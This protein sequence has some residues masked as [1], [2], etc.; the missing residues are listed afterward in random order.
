MLKTQNCAKLRSKGPHEMD[1][2][3]T[4]HKG[5]TPGCI[6]AFTVV[7]L[8]AHGI[9]S[10]G[11]LVAVM[12][13][14]SG[15]EAYVM[16][17]MFP[18]KSL[19]LFLI[20]FIVGIAAGPITDTLFKPGSVLAEKMSGHLEFHKEDECICY[21]KGEILNQYRN[22]SLERASLILLLVLFTAAL[23]INQLGPPAWNWIK[24][25]LLISSLLALFV[26]STVPEHF[27]EEHLWEHIV[28]VHIPR[29]FLWTFGALLAMYFLMDYLALGGWIKANYLTVMV[30]ACLI[31]LI[32][33][34]GPH[35]IFVTLYAQ[36]A[37]PFGVLLA[38]SIVQDGH[39]MLPL[40]AESKRSFLSVKMI[41]FV[42]ALV[43]GIVCYVAGF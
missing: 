28:K 7:A 43:A 30:I 12:I 2:G 16:L 21:P 36:G 29:V 38:S 6:G 15:D 13:A 23:L 31:G 35:M 1:K 4:L 26:V 10:F 39:G 19:L 20:T 8:Y 14:T 33:E 22:L 25:T 3:F 34:S 41:N 40:L 42:V 11:A 24:V 17:S 9:V 5:V 18:A 27:L 37:I 32:P